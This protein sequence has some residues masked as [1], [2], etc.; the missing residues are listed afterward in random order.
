[1]GSFDG[2]EICQLVGLFL[3]AKLDKY[4]PKRYVGL[5]RDDG[6]A[7]LKSSGPKLE[8]LKKKI[9]KL[10]QN[11]DLKVTIEL[12]LKSTDFLDIYLNL[13]DGSYKPYKKP[14][15]EISYVHLKS[16]HP[17]SIVNNIP[18][19]VQKRISNLSKSQD[20][21][22]QEIAVY[23]NALNRSGY[24][25]K[26]IY[27]DEK[28]EVEKPENKNR[29]RRRNV[30]WY[31][32]PFNK[33]VST[34]VASKFLRL[35]D[36]HF[37]KNSPF[38]KLF[39]R[40]NVKVS[41]CC[42]PNMNSIISSHNRKLL[43]NPHPIVTKK[44]NCRGGSNN[45]PLQGNC[46]VRSVIYKAIVENDNI[47]NNQNNRT[48][49]N[50]LKQYAEYIGQ[51]SNTFKERY[52]NH[53]LSFKHEKYEHNTG[54]SKY[55]WELKRNNIKFKINWSILSSATTY[56]PS[57]GTCNLCNLEK[58]Y[59]LRSNHTFQLNKKSEML[60]KCNHRDKFLL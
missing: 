27:L 44:C 40:N 55:V 8:Q 16:N 48:S 24:K 37:P 6:L 38:N 7:V 2:A 51:A 26:L 42:L 5:Y 35:L 3:L 53:Q 9:I 33:E 58:T 50:E 20:I 25:E 41:Y 52:N 12:N 56:H 21:F 39:N 17:P 19:M 22:Q 18:K 14:N 59:I 60:R 28:S 54:L 4:I 36:K 45:C 43:K 57:V 32:P 10:F 30:L 49:S 13:T 47:K 23:Q 29:K 46:L 15:Q 11:F 1:M 31:N 34:N